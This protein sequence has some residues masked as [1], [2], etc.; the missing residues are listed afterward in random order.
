MLYRIQIDMRLD[1]MKAITDAVKT[2]TDSFIVLTG[3]AYC[4]N[5]TH[6]PVQIIEIEDD[7]GNKIDFGPCIKKLK[8]V[9]NMPTIIVKRYPA[10]VW[11]FS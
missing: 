5:N 11:V 4:D 2:V 3:I 10:T 7:S 9:L 6:K 8:K 1:K